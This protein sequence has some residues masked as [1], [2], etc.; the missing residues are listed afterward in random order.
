[1]VK[2]DPHVVLGVQAGASSA[3][4]AAWRRLARENHPDLTGDDPAASRVA[5]RR[6]AEINDAYAALVRSG[7]ATGDAGRRSDGSAVRRRTAAPASGGPPAPKPTR[8]VTGRVDTSATYRPRNHGQ[9]GPAR[10][11][12]AVWP[13]AAP[14]RYRWPRVAAG[15][16]PERPA[17]PRSGPRVPA[18]RPPT[19]PERHGPRLA[20]SASSMATPSARSRRSSRP[21]STGWSGRSCAIRRWR[22]RHAWCRPTSIAAGS[23][24]RRHRRRAGPSEAP[25]EPTRNASKPSDTGGLR[26]R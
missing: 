22:H 14:C 2:R 12:P 23:Q 26:G 18:A 5:T 8:P 9:L 11:G 20:S 3:I 25:R 16:R 24:R 15:L 10:G 19:P 6:M 4:K 1:M 7:D 17:R 13:A 21:T